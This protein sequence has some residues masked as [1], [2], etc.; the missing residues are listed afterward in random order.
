MPLSDKDVSDRLTELSAEARA[1]GIP[2]KKFISVLAQAA[3]VDRGAAEARAA[4][5]AMPKDLDLKKVEKFLDAA[6]GHD[7]LNAAIDAAEAHLAAN[8]AEGF[9][10]SLLLVYKIARGVRARVV[11]QKRAPLFPL[12]ES[13]DPAK[14]GGTK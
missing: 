10:A 5:P 7:D 13:V 4:V 6:V 9:W 11:K 12:P 2:V 8:D 3:E 1:R 14:T